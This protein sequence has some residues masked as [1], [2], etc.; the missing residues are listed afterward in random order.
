MNTSA[1]S[2]TACVLSCRHFPMKHQDVKIMAPG[3]ITSPNKGISEHYVF[4]IRSLSKYG[5]A[6]V[7]CKLAVSNLDVRS[8]FGWENSS[9]SRGQSISMQC[10][11]FLPQGSIATSSL[12]LCLRCNEGKSRKS[13]FNRGKHKQNLMFASVDDDF[14][15]TKETFLP[16]LYCRRKKYDDF[17]I[18]HHSS[19]YDVGAHLIT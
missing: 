11:R 5:S 14:I 15:P 1:S 18:Y 3:G 4:F 2:Y 7:A 17:Y 16:M 9:T 19:S 6:K 13:Y 12:V 8:P 10:H